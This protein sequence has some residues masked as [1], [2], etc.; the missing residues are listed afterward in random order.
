MH[1]IYKLVHTKIVVNIKIYKKKSLKIV[2][3]KRN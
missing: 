2:T 3:L 1:Y